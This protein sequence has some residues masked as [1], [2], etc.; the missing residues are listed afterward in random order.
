MALFPEKMGLSALLDM[1]ESTKQTLVYTSVRSD[2][3]DRVYLTATVDEK[4]YLMA[5]DGN[6]NLCAV[7]GG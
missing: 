6:G 1:D 5:L 3:S 4:D 7:Q 2:A